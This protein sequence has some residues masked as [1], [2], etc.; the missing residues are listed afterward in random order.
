M[1]RLISVI[2]FWFLVA[3]VWAEGPKTPIRIA[4][5]GLDHDAAGDFISRARARSD[6]QLVGIVEPNQTLVRTYVQLLNLSTNLFYPD[7]ESLVAKT[8]VQA[9]AVFTT[10]FDHRKAVE[11]CAAHKM[12][13][14]LEKPLAVNMD[15]A[16]AM[17]AAAKSNGIQIIVDFE[18][19]WYSSVGTAYAMVHKQHAIGD[20]RKIIV[21][22]GDQGPKDAGCSDTFL[23]WLT[24][25]VLNGGGALTDFGCYGAG[26]ITWFADGQRP[27][28]VFAQAN[29][30]KPQIYPKVEDEATIVITYPQLQGIVQASW[31]LPFAERSLQIYGD[32]G[33][34]FAPRMDLLRLRLA[35]TEE[36]ELELQTQPDPGLMSDDISYFAAVVR[37][38]IKPTG[39]S[40]LQANLVTTEILDAA[41]KSI[42]L[43]KQIDL[44]K[45]PLWQD[46]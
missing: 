19:S 8:N 5:I 6:F 16:L 37:G 14:M 46:P 40:S 13:V 24:N 25:P 15:D 2:L 33:Y 38:E 20:L 1:K 42:E 44:P 35:G 7:L 36:S 39:P 28:S 31:N 4:V 43:R 22:A 32:S 34:I 41:R 30:F 23:E 21:I 18:T 12:D 3:P 45:S 29:N 17:A 27:D 9:A 26:L 10:T 11:A